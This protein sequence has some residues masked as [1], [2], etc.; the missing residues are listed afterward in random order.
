MKSWKKSAQ[1][2]ERF[3]KIWN[4]IGLHIDPNSQLTE[5]RS[6]TGTFTVKNPE[7]EATVAQCVACNRNGSIT[8]KTLV[9]Q[10]EKIDSIF[11]RTKETG[12]T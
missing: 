5:I 12:K 1:F 10:L 4:Y 7:K 9:Y 2:R 6:T 11:F 3:Q 8:C